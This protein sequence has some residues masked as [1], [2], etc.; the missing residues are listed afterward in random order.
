MHVVQMSDFVANFISCSDMSVL[1][2][3]VAHTE[4]VPRR[5][6][7]NSLLFLF[8]LKKGGETLGRPCHYH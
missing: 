6:N 4:E 2:H 7:A 3:Y 5:C 1:S 8:I